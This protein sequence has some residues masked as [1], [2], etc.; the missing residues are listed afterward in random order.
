MSSTAYP[1]LIVEDDS[2]LSELIKIQLTD[3]DYEIE[4]AFHGRI[5]LNKALENKYSLI[6]LDVMLPEV[7][8]FEICKSIRKEDRQIPILMLT[9]KAEEAD[10]IMG[11]EYGADDYL[12][13]PFSIKELIARVKALLRRASASETEDSSKLDQMDFGDLVIYP[14]KRSVQLQDELIELT[15]KEFELL[16]LFANNPGRA[17]SRQE[18]LDVVWGYQYS[19]YSHTVNSHIN[20]LRSKIEKNPSEPKYITTVWGMGYKFAELE[21]LGIQ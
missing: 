14:K 6:I 11:L 17:Y 19:G 15:S 2:D 9:A 3:N 16:L 7:D 8:G 10:K 4:Q 21:E 13:K 5:A 12:T 18:L 1:I 20:R